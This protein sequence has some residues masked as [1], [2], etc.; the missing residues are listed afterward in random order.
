MLSTA[1]LK[2]LSAPVPQALRK[3]EFS[4]FKKA[5]EGYTFDLLKPPKNDDAY[6]QVSRAAAE[7]HA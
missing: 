7:R 4:S 6:Q 5:V 1:C 2:P 3:M